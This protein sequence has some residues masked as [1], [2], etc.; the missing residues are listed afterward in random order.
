VRWGEP[1]GAGSEWGAIGADTLAGIVQR[2]E[3]ELL[4]IWDAT[5]N[6]AGE[7]LAPESWLL[8]AGDWVA[9]LV[10][11]VSPL[12]DDY[13]QLVLGTDQPLVEGVPYTLTPLATLGGTV[14]IG[15]AFVGKQVSTTTQPDLDFLDI[16]QQPFEPYRITPGGDHGMAAGYATFRKIVI[17]RLLTLRGTVPWAPLHGAA[18]GHKQPRPL[19]LTAAATHI[20][21]LLVTVPGMLS[22]SVQLKWDTSGSKPQLLAD[23]DARGDT[24]ALQETVRL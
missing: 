1:W 6:P 8:S 5:W 3:N 7:G 20:E 9:P 24:G 10:V 21:S 15:A 2:A 4:T 19:D 18:L 17:G 11:D 22:V 16:D 14:P 13:S 12:G 23:I